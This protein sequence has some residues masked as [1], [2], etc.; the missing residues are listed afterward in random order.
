MASSELSFLQGTNA[1]AV[2]CQVRLPDFEGPLDLLLHLIRSHE[3]DI[4]DLSVS[5]VTEQY[6]SYLHYMHDMNIDVAS[7]YLVMAATLTFIK[8]QLVLPQEKKEEKTG[9]DPRQALIQQLVRLKCYKDLAAMFRERPQLNRENFINGQNVLQT[10]EDN[11]ER[12]VALSNPFQL[13]QAL[14]NVFERKRTH[15]HEVVTDAV[16]IGSCIRTIVDTLK[17]KEKATLADVLP[18]PYKT[19]QLISTFLALLEMTK[20]QYTGLTQEK[21]FGPIEFYRLGT[22]D[23]LEDIFKKFDASEWE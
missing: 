14:E 9:P 18:N 16:P 13:T 20:L 15:V 19:P 10:F 3:M 22:Q 11:L 5:K 21:T 12:S 7:E 2:D 6:L 1:P 23:E 4:L 8:S 17:D